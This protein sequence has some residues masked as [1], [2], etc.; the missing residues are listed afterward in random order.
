[1]NFEKSRIAQRHG[2]PTEFLRLAVWVL[3][4]CCIMSGAQGGDYSKPVLKVGY[5]TD[6][7]V[8][9]APADEDR[10]QFEPWVRELVSKNTIGRT[11]AEAPYPIEEFREK[12]GGDPPW[13]V[14][15]MY[16]YDFVE[17]RQR[18]NLDALLV[19]SWSSEPQV[20]YSLY[21]PSSS[22]IT[23]I[24]D[25][26]QKSILIEVN[27][28]G[29][30]PYAWLDNQ[31]RKN[32][33]NKSADEVCQVRDVSSPLLAALPVYFQEDGYEACLLSSSGFKQVTAGNSAVGTFLRPLA[34]APKLLTHV[35]ACRKDLPNEH[36]QAI[37]NISLAFAERNSK[38]P[39]SLRFSAFKPE[40][41]E[42]VQQ[43]WMEYLTN[44][45]NDPAQ[46]QEKGN[47]MPKPKTLIEARAA[48]TGN[49]D[50]TRSSTSNRKDGGY[51]YPK[52]D[53]SMAH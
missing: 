19:P 2:G 23:K 43:E 40:Y 49:T 47:S 32:C 37:I 10:T 29:L 34:A 15:P 3:T 20:E 46:R 22:R 38:A 28:R 26:Q 21:V 35:I 39:N 9:D 18:C 27:G 31:I 11:E 4:V 36:R 1:M 48:A 14:F 51:R 44:F 41:L 13:D 6:K 24:S 30:L 17:L 50:A 25:L 45:L 5:F 8:M 16:A 52:P 42:N 12:L 7:N 33:Q 53:N